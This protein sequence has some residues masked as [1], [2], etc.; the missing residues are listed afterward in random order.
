MERSISVLH[1]FMLLLSGTIIFVIFFVTTLN[2]LKQMSIFQR[3]TAVIVAICVS[4][5]SII[6]LSRFFVV[7]D[8]TCETTANRCDITLDIILLPYTALALSIVLILFLRFVG[9][10]F[11]NHKVN[12]SCEE[13]PRRIR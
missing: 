9:R 5:L 12:K 4:L 11:R 6:G 7:P 10:I 8:V 1:E 13:I 2:V 3:T